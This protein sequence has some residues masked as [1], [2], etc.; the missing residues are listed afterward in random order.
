[1]IVVLPTFSVIDRYYVDFPFATRKKV[2]Q[3]NLM[4]FGLKHEWRNEK[5]VFVHVRNSRL[6]SIQVN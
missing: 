2:V 6:S 3:Y 1:M 4:D 5:N